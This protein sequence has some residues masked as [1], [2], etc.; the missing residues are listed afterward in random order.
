MITLDTVCD[1]CGQ[2]LRVR[3][4]QKE[5]DQYQAHVM[6]H[7]CKETISKNLKLKLSKVG[8]IL[9]IEGTEIGRAHV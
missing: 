6:P 5:Q 7:K 3:V 1:R 2:V 4:E 8:E 9:I